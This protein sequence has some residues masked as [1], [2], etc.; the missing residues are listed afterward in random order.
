MTQTRLFV[1]QTRRQV[2]NAGGTSKS[3]AKNAPAT[4]NQYHLKP[5]TN[6]RTLRIFGRGERGVIVEAS[7]T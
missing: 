1:A 5:K 3:L 4:A 7:A 2:A 6:K